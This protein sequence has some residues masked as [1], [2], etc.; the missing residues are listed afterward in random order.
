MLTLANLRKNKGQAVSVTLIIALAT[1]FLSLGLTVLTGL[2]GFLNQRAEELHAPHVVAVETR[3][4]TN[5][6]RLEFIQGFPNVIET[7]TQAVIAGLGGYYNGDI[8]DIIPIIIADGSQPQ[9]MNPL[10][11]VGDY[12]TLEGDAIYVPRSVFLMGGFEIGDHITLSFLGQAFEF[13]VAGS[14]E[15]IIFGGADLRFYVS[16]ERFLE[17]EVQFFYH[18]FTLLSA[19]LSESGDIQGLIN[20]YNDQFFGTT[21]S[22]STFGSPLSF[23]LDREWLT[24]QVSELPG[25]IASLLSAFALI[26]LIVTI[27]VVRFRITSTIEE[28]MT[29]IG[30][31]KAMGYRNHQIM[32]SMILQ[33][34]LLSLIGSV[35]GI[36][37]ASVLVT[38]FVSTIEPLTGLRWNPEFGVIFTAIIICSL[39][40][41]V[42]VFSYF[43]TR[44]IS[45]LHPLVALRGG[46]TTHNFKKNP[47]SL[48]KSSGSLVMLLALKQLLQ[49]MKQ[50]FAIALIVISLMVASMI[51]LTTYYNMNVNVDTFVGI[52]AGN[53]LPD[54]VLI[55]DNNTGGET[56]VDNLRSREEIEILYGSNFMRLFADDVLVTATIITDFSYLL[57]DPLSTGR[58]PLHDNE[59]VVGLPG[60]RAMNKEVGDWIAIRTGDVEVNYMVTGVIAGSE[61]MGLS[62]MMSEPAFEKLVPDTVVSQFNLLMAEGVNAAEFIE[63]V[64][65][66]EESGIIQMINMADQIEGAMEGLEEVFTMIAVLILSVT[67]VVIA[68]VLYMVIKT[69]I[70]RRRRELGIQKALGFTT[71]QLMNQIIMSLI[72]TVLMGAIIGAVAGY[73]SFNPMFV[74]LM[75]AQGITEANFS[76]PLVWTTIT[77][78][79]IVIF[80]YGI[81]MLISWRIR[82]I[83][84]YSLVTE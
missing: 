34:G 10:T 57:N 72:P 76:I 17:L 78:I 14:M 30:A 22:I 52:V 26:I 79:G 62:V 44:R 81:S 58:L 75:S 1:I 38:P 48:D 66:R 60:L 64:I 16:H 42:A 71:W 74:L 6:D 70:R 18:Q 27:I 43:A 11:L 31:L 13:I 9:T 32:M 8:L 84:A 61:H 35:V 29:N 45:K 80:A 68:L 82:K 83:S 20:G 51:G 56:V 49:N 50:A 53:N 7:E 41:L 39:V 19:R 36:V 28:S 24:G 40:L 15:D 21:Y 4:T 5:N 65:S 47:L 73:V 25:V 59:V 37:L 77:T 63:D 12:L 69:T 67:G 2:E 23:P 3:Y 55:V 54:I 46:L 33:F